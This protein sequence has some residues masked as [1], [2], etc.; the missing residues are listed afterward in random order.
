[1]GIL[2]IENR[3]EN[4]KTAVSFSP[5]FRNQ[6]LRLC[7]VNRLGEPD[8]TDPADIRLELFWKG[9]RDHLHQ[10]KKKNRDKLL[11]EGNVTR[12]ADH[13]RTHFRKLRDEIESFGEFH[14]LQELNY[15]LSN[16]QWTTKLANNLLN[17]EIDIVLETPHYLY[18]GEAKDESSFGAN[19][20]LVLVHQL[21]REY[22]MAEIVVALK[23]EEKKVVP[24][25]V[26]NKCRIDSIK[27]HSQVKFMADPKR[28]WLN[29]SNILS[30][31]YI[32]Q[33][34]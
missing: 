24:F 15:S 17:T 12:L 4:W 26:G 6:D 29:E 9:M 7:L 34:A 30:W 33:L 18:I 8:G 32:K 16:G 20:T 13:Y 10:N 3:T 25:V 23:G 31:D 27:N 5:F 14:G 2:G 19:G 11:S 1:M 21:I 22:V 28:G